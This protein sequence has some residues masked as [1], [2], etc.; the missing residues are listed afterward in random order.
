MAKGTKTLNSAIK[1][2]DDG[3]IFLK[4]NGVEPA[5]AD[6]AEGEIVYWID[7]SS[8]IVLTAKARVGGNV[9]SGAVATLA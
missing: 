4:G 8:G 3:N 6:I 9:V 1:V 2:D 7:T 5:D